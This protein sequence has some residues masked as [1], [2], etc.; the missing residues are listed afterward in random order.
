[1]PV[2]MG[3]GRERLLADKGIRFIV[4]GS[5][6][7]IASANQAEAREPSCQDHRPDEPLGGS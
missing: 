2:T 4:D 5:F 3:I 1:M 6:N 7:R